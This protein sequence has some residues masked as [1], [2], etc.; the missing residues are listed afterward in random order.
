MTVYI[1]KDIY[2]G[3]V[4]GGVADMS[5]FAIAPNAPV[6][7]LQPVRWVNREARRAA[8]RARRRKA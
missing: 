1:P 2:D 8:A 6:A 3:M 5:K 7:K 4:A